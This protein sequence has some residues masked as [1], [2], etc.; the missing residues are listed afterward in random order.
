[1]GCE[2]GL[3]QPGGPTEAILDYSHDPIPIDGRT[4]RDLFHEE[5]RAIR[6]VFRAGFET[7]V[8][9]NVPFSFGTLFRTTNPSA[10]HIPLYGLYE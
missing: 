5:I 9:I 3:L 2:V 7:R 6:R 4:F 8:S 1:M 10:M